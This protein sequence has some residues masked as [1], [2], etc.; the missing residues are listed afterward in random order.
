MKSGWRSAATLCG[1]MLLTAACQGPTA[2]NDNQSTPSPSTAPVSNP[3][4]APSA[5]PSAAPS[6]ASDLAVASLPVHN[7][8]VG[9]GYLAVTLT[10]TGGVAPYTWAVAGGKFPPGLN[11]SPAGVITGKN[12]T[13]GKF[14]F[15]VKVTDATGATATGNTSIGV[16]AALAVSQP[17]ATLCMV[18]IDCTTCGKFGAVT[19]GL[20]PYK[21]K[22]VGGAV[23]SGMTWSSLTLSG[24]FP[25]PLINPIPVDVVGPP[26][27]VR[28]T[29][30]MTVQVSD[31]FGATRNVTGNWQ[32]FGPINL[33]CPA[34]TQCI[35]CSSTGTPGDCADNTI[36]YASGSPDDNVTVKVTGVFDSQGNPI[37]L[38][39]NWSATADAGTVSISMSCN[40]QCP[41][42][43]GGFGNSFYADV[44]IQL[45]DNGRCVAPAHK[46]SAE[47]IVNIDI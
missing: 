13:A 46:L 32:L 24:A 9:I 41:D 18:G 16:F 37:A 31:V 38:P 6:A 27:P 2:S 30:G 34:G 22:V 17:C 23:P 5:S 12:T 45:V 28:I 4:T 40:N 19:G 8:E 1:L 33:K 35:S 25:L 11:L 15:Q 14:P 26:V 7:G 36:Q 10:A 47:A 43:N 29:F 39:P 42:G 21:Y 3:T 20:A 44:H